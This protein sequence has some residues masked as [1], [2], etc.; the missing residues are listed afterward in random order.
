MGVKGNPGNT[1]PTG[2][3]GPAGGT[4]TKGQKGVVFSCCPTFHDEVVPICEPCGF[5]GAPEELSGFGS[6]GWLKILK[7][8]SSTR[9]YYFPYW[10]IVP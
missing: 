10:I 8:G 2:P 6:P 1:G 4:G 5:I 9:Y 7:A 3:Q